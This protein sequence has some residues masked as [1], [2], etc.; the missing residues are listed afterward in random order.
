MAIR[1]RCDICKNELSDFGALLFSPPDEAGF[2]QK[3][4]VCASCYEIMKQT[5]N[6]KEEE[7][8]RA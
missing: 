3:H 5:Y 1:P 4:H 6:L 7:P 8:E 2:V